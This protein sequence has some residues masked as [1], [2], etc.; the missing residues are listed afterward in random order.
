MDRLSAGDFGDDVGVEHL[1][2][3]V[4]ADDLNLLVFAQTGAGGDE[5]TA[6]NVL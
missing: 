3:V 5:V 6:D 1:L 2:Q 4:L